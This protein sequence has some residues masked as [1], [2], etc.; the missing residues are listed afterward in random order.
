MCIFSVN[1]FLSVLDTRG[2]KSMSLCLASFVELGDMPMLR[3][4]TQLELDGE[5][6]VSFNEP[7]LRY[8][9]NK[10]LVFIRVGRGSAFSL[11]CGD[12]SN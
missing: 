2:L 11:R 1:D 9:S 12:G 5:G 4:L 8:V 7:L 3:S 6:S 10:W